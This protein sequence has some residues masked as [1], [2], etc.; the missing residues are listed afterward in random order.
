MNETSSKLPRFRQ[1]GHTCDK[2]WSEDINMVF[3]EGKGWSSRYGCA[4]VELL[5]TSF[6]GEHICLRCRRCNYSWPMQT[7]Q[8]EH[9]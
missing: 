3:H 2:C 4:A 5:V 7:A 1:E 8:G 6:P 9:L